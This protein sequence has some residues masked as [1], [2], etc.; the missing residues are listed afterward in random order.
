MAR[1]SKWG[2]LA[3]GLGAFVGAG[4]QANVLA[5]DPLSKEGPVL[6][7]ENASGEV[8]IRIDG[9]R[10]YLSERGREFEELVLGDTPEAEGLRRLVKELL[11]A[12]GVL[13]V[14]VGPSV[15]AEGGA[16]GPWTRPKSKNDGKRGK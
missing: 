6:A 5:P 4:A 1:L 9:E 11:P 7:G 3:A 8:R 15:V 14:P 2:A 12:G 13:A 16:H 10:L